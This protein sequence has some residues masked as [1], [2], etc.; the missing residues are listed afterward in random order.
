MYFFSNDKMEEI[1]PMLASELR[2]L[3]KK[4][5]DEAALTLV[6]KVYDR[7]LSAANEGKISCT[8]KVEEVTSQ[9][10]GSYNLT[11]SEMV[12]SLKLKFPDSDI[13]YYEEWESVRPGTPAKKIAVLII[14]WS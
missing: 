7:V 4:R 9:S 11:S 1:K 2:L 13:K 14:T 12:S 5:R 8:I 3:P 6:R 10:P